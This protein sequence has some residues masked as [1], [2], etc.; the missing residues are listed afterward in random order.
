MGPARSTA[1][2]APCS[3]AAS[4]VVFNHLPPRA[5]SRNYLI[6]KGVSFGPRVAIHAV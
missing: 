5:V 6:S 3:N 2:A 1:S 4:A